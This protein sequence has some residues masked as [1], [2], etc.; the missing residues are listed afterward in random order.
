MQSVC[1]ADSDATDLNTKVSERARDIAVWYAMSVINGGIVLELNVPTE[2]EPLILLC[3]ATCEMNI[4]DTMRDWFP[5][6]S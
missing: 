1:P 3:T 5:K 4:R 6:L 2:S